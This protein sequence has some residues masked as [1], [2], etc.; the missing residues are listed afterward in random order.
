MVKISDINAIPV[1]TS[2]TTPRGTAS[3]S[4]VQA[5]SASYYAFRAFDNNKDSGWVSKTSTDEWLEYDFPANCMVA[6][7]TISHRSLG[8]VTEAPKSW[9]FE[10]FNGSSWVTLDSID[11]QVGWTQGEE[12]EFY[13]QNFNYY[14]KYRLFF[15]SNNGQIFIGIGEL[16]MFEAIP[17]KRVALKN[18]TTNQNYSLADKTLIHLPS[19]SDKNM[20]SYGIEQGKEIQLDVPFTKHI[21]VNDTP[22]GRHFT[23]QINNSNTLKVREIKKDNGYTP[24][25]TWYE[26]RM[27]SNTA[28][29]PLVASASSVYNDPRYL[30]FKAFNGTNLDAN[31]VFL[32]ASG[33]LTGW[34]QIDFGKN[35]QVDSIRITSINLSG[36]VTATPKDMKFQGSLDGII[37][38]DIYTLPPQTGWGANETRSFNLGRQSN[39]R[40]Y[41]LVVDSNNG[42]T[43]YT[44]IG[45]LVFGYK[46]EVN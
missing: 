20:I 42:Y 3:A 40:F 11:N 12:R 41:R 29:S 18:P 16:K 37:F 26:T 17:E 19:T 1:M 35:T 6:K 30:E 21:Y 14:K 7:Y 10:A 45:Q 5:D 13:V 27:T 4:S 8:Q 34:L 22:S 28:P 33:V 15:T 24:I 25:F 2:N 44:A 31:D 32:F 23:Q 9:R 38:E 43:S 39:F 46:R 36:S